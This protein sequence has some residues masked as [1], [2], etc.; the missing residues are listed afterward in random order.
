[1]SPRRVPGSFAGSMCRRLAA[2]VG[3]QFRAVERL[4]PHRRPR[5][6]HLADEAADFI[7]ADARE[8]VLL[9]GRVAG[10]Q[11][12]EQ[13]AEGVD[14][15][16]RVDVQRG[17]LRLLGRHVERRADH[18]LELRIDRLLDEPPLRRL[19]HAEINHLRHRLPVVDRHEDVR[20]L[21]I[22]MDDSFLMRVLHRLADGDEQL[23][24]LLRGELLLIA[25]VRD[26]H[27]AHQFHDEGRPPILRRARIEH[28]RDVQ[29]NV[30]SA[31][32]GGCG[33]RTGG[34][35]GPD[36]RGGGGGGEGMGM[37]ISPAHAKSGEEK[38]QLFFRCNHE[39]RG[40]IKSGAN[41]K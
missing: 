3:G 13:H 29:L 11:F 38:D 30:A 37:F 26:L 34:F 12:V 39:R 40:V 41:V 8:R 5:R 20:R 24:A 2:V 32:A 18:L 22:A 19:R 7:H 17:Q 14:V 35:G 31:C 23:D 28:L 4:H 10:E 21:E 16:A 15:A 9:D 6:V 27:P 1:M 33:C 25:V 36:D